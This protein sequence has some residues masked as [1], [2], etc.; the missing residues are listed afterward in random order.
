ME[1][2]D[3]YYYEGEGDSLNEQKQHG[4]EGHRDLITG[5]CF[6]LWEAGDDNTLG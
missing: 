1:D 4:N 6:L 5:L 2:S 3:G